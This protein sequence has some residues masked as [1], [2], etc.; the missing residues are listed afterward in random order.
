[1]PTPKRYFHFSRDVN[2]DPEVWE[3]T[4][5][6][7]D[8]HF[9]LLAELLAIL[10]KR[11]NEMPVTAAVLNGLARKVR[12]T[13]DSVIR[14][15]LWMVTDK[16][17]FT[18]SG[19]GAERFLEVAK[20][21][22]EGCLR[23]RRGP[24]GGSLN[25]RKSLGDVQEVSLSAPNY[26]KYHRKPERRGDEQGTNEEQ[27][28]I[29]ERVPPNLP[30][31]N[32]IKERININYKSVFDFEIRE[33]FRARMKSEN[34]PDPDA[35]LQR[36]REFRANRDKTKQHT[37]DEWE[38]L[39]THQLRYLAKHPEARADTPKSFNNVGHCTF[40]PKT[41]DQFKEFGTQP[42][43]EPIYS[44]SKKYCQTHFDYYRDLTAYLARDRN[45]G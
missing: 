16:E 10:D 38:Y 18:V 25:L 40:E 11:E 7:T 24:L 26:W 14:A 15:I 17:W 42:C 1:M 32:L 33:E 41:P 23:G 22:E 31:P 34:L 36:F 27:Q 45:P 21:F 3:L 8:R 39:Y 4:E 20:S 37:Q 6:F 35:N 5:R 44:G 43:L 9:R 2:E 19:D 29:G 28:G 30:Y 12:V 13:P